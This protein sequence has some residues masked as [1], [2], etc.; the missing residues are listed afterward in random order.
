MGSAA[1]LGVLSV[2]A[3][4]C[5]TCRNTESS[6]RVRVQN[7]LLSALGAP[8]KLDRLGLL[9]VL[10]VCIRRQSCVSSIRKLNE[11]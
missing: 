1:I 8:R 5:L 2:T 11:D 9:V 10:T 7:V 3:V 6:N 4:K